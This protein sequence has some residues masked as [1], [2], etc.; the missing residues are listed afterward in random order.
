MQN[1]INLV[2]P[3]VRWMVRKRALERWETKFTNCEVTPQVIWP[4]AK[5]LTKGDGP[6][7]LSAI[8]VP[9]GPIFYPVDRANIIANCLENQFTT[10]DL[11]DCYHRRHVE[12]QV[13]ALPATVDED[14]PVNF[15][16]C[17]VSKVIRSLKLGKACGFDGIRNERLRHLPRRP[18][19][20]LT[21][22]FNHC[23]RHGHFPEPCMETKFRTLPKPGIP[24]NLRPTSLLSTTGKLF[25][26]LIWRTIQKDIEEETNL[27][28]AS[29]FQADYSTTL[30]WMRMAITSS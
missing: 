19:V 6:K 20:H 15:R 27:L 4:V 10:H 14:A 23:L 12:A 9:L 1:C 7:A 22:L 29:Q 25:E 3:N 16:P 5:S 8:H 11:C 26:K 21:H 2:T 30:Q 18:L 13:E 24:Q 28:N 17:D